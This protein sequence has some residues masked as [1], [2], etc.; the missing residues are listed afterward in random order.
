MTSIAVLMVGVGIIW[1]VLWALKNERTGKVGDQNGLF[2][3]RDWA[4]EIEHEG[5]ANKRQ[6]GSRQP[7]NRGGRLG[8]SVRDGSAAPAKADAAAPRKAGVTGE[9]RPSKTANRSNRKRL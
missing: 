9:A 8:H 3:M 1:L 2:R 5:E 6:T 4:A 7:G